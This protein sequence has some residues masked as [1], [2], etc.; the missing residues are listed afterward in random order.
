MQLRLVPRYYLGHQHLNHPDH[1]APAHILALTQTAI[2]K[3]DD[4]LEGI[5][6]LLATVVAEAASKERGLVL[7]RRKGQGSSGGEGKGKH[8]VVSEVKGPVSPN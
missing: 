3:P 7:A 5:V 4:L 1:A 2:G 8:I 6:E